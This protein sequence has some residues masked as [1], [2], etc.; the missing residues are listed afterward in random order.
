[1]K[2]VAFYTLGCKLNF[3]ESAELSRRFTENGFEVVGNEQ[4]TDVVVV[5]SCCVTERSERECRQILRRALRRSPSAFIVVAGCYSQMDQEKLSSIKGIDLIV[6]SNEKNQILEYLHDLKK[7]EHPAIIVSSIDEAL[8]FHGAHSGGFQDRT[9]AFLKIQDGCDYRCTY[10][11]VPLARGAS[12]SP[13]IESIVPQAQR[14]VN[15]GYKEIVLTGVNV[16]DY[17]RKIGSN[18]L[19]LLKQLES[20]D[21]LE[22]IRISSIEPNLLTDELISFW[23]KSP[24]ICNHWHIPL[25]SGSNAI[26]KKM[27]RR[28]LR[29]V[30]EEKVWSIK[31]QCTDAGI[32]CDVITG[33]PGETEALF[34]ETSEFLTRLPLSY[35]HVFTFSARP[36]T[37]AATMENN[38]EP[39]IKFFRTEKLRTL[40]QTKKDVHVK[41][42]AHK[43]KKVLIETSGADDYLTGLTE[44]YVRVRVRG[45]KSL[46]NTI[47]PVNIENVAKG[48]GYGTVVAEHDIYQ[49]LVEKEVVVCAG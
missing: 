44:E 48:F 16:G 30:F 37:I 11:T 12:R 5:N 36:H 47:V 24:I 49:S 26:L 33:F 7:R 19:E 13:M 32:G 18:L 10:C 6:G 8:P 45:N 25:Q 41:S 35:L 28:Y 14:L 46:L 40:G 15:D 23:I 22:R 4:Q 29:E 3:A 20:I 9:R 27:G 1:M 38:N 21:G 31:S 43:T 17:G 42:F 39:R 34:E 2:T